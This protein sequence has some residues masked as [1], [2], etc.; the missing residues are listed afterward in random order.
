MISKE[1]AL[2]ALAKFLFLLEHDL[3]QTYL[4]KDDA[5]ANYALKSEL[6]TGQV[7]LSTD[8]STVEGALWLEWS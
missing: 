5:A 4:S 6:G 3:S 7:V 1:T 8:T 2:T